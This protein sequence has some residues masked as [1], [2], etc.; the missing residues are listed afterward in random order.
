M[1]PHDL[2]ETDQAACYDAG[3]CRRPNVRPDD[4]LKMI[5]EQPF[6]P[7]R[8]YL[9]YGQTFEV[10]HPELAW[11][12]R[13]TLMIAKPSTELPGAVDDYDVIALIHIN[14]IELLPAPSTA[15]K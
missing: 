15:T 3:V 6:R 11:V 14:R 2:V 7:F 13:S 5:R 9:S 1:S 10:R 4:L 12:T 8:I